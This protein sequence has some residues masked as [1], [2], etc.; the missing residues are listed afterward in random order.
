MIFVMIYERIIVTI[1]KNPDFAPNYKL[2]LRFI[3]KNVF[4]EGGVPKM[5]NNNLHIQGILL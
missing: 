2:W 4:S 3:K 5:R 1:Y